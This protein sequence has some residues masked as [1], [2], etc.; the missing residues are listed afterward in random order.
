MNEKR[1]DWETHAAALIGT[2]QAHLTWAVM[3]LIEDEKLQQVQ[4]DGDLSKFFLSITADDPYELIELPA[5]NKRSQYLVKDRKMELPFMEDGLTKKHKDD[6]A[7]SGL[8]REQLEIYKREFPETREFIEEALKKADKDECTSCEEKKIL[9]KVAR[10]VKAAGE[11]PP[12]AFAEPGATYLDKEPGEETTSAR[13]PCADCTRKHVSQA[14][15]LINESHQ[16]Y[17]A[18]RWLAIGHLAEASDE[19]IG[20]WPSVARE[21]REERL[22]LMDDPMYIPNLMQYLEMEYVD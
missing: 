11:V 20:K 3:H 9:V 17:P 22:L 19:S 1:V 15:I 14:I 5:I 12:I 13:E 21:L 7:A 18:H 4:K 2:G 16:G 10:M 8:L 6:L